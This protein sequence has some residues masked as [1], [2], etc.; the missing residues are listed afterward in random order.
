MQRATMMKAVTPAH[1]TLGSVEM[2][3]TA[4]V[5]S[6]PTAITFN[7]ILISL[8][9]DECAEGTHNCHVMSNA[10]CFNTDG[11][12]YCECAQGFVGNGITCKGR[13]MT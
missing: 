2:D 4:Q 13:C 7:A 1:V 5:Q 9:V 10:T 11:G 8:D 6:Q 12:L 3:S